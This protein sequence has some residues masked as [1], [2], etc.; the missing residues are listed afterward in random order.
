[1][2]RNNTILSLINF[3]DS[4]KDIYILFVRNRRALRK[5]STESKHLQQFCRK[6]DEVYN[7]LDSIRGQCVF[8]KYTA[9]GGIGSAK[10]SHNQNSIFQHL[11]LDKFY[12]LINQYSS[13]GNLKFYE[14]E[15]NNL[16][17]KVPS[18]N[19]MTCSCGEKCTLVG[20]YTSCCNKSIS[21]ILFDVFDEMYFNTQKS[22]A[23]KFEGSGNEDRPM[24][25]ACLEGSGSESE[26]D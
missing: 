8:V 2:N 1:M 9:P 21:D 18:F 14:N 17:S 5:L 19:E 24:F 10:E 7:E 15:N 12:G 13:G 16:V 4:C 26:E 3:A 25:Y 23:M 6:T 20:G 11:D 22:Y